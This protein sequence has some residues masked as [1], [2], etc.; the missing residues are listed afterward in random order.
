MNALSVWTRLTVTPWSAKN[1]SARAT[2]AV[3]VGAR[4]SG[5][6]SV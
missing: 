4:S 6:I 2:K 1:A 5:W 3:T